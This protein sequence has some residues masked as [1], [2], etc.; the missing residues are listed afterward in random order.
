[1]IDSATRAQPSRRRAATAGSLAEDAGHLR[2]IAHVALDNAP[3]H[4]HGVDKWMSGYRA[5]GEVEVAAEGRLDDE[6]FTGLDGRH[7]PELRAA[8]R[9]QTTDRKS[10]GRER[11]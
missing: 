2:A 5:P 9:N 1:M 3:G 4:L 6:F 7:Q 10:V 8:D 11:V